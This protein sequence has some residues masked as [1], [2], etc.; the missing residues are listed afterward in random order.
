M[1]ITLFVLPL[2]LVLCVCFLDHCLSFCS[3]SF[4]HFAECLLIYT[5]S[6]F[7][8][9]RLRCHNV[10][11]CFGWTFSIVALTRLSDV[12]ITLSYHQPWIK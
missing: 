8:L 10:N 5:L 11:S 9:S 4:N 6:L 12:T 7:T 1:T 3:F 2:Y